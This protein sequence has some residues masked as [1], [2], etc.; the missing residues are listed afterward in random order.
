AEFIEN[1]GTVFRN[2]R[3]CFQGNVE[4]GYNFIKYSDGYRLVPKGIISDFVSVG[5]DVGRHEDFTVFSALDSS[6]YLVGFERFRKLDFQHQKDRLKAF[7]SHFPNRVVS[8][9]ARG[10]G[11]SFYEELAR[12]GIYMEGIKL[13]NPLKNELI[14][15]LILKLDEEA[16]RGPY[17]EVL[18]D[19]LEAFTYH[20]SS[21]GNP[22]YSAPSN[23]HDDCVMSLA[24]AAKNVHK[25]ATDWI[26]LK[27]RGY[28]SRRGEGNV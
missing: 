13:T 19:E 5:I 6:G 11:E 2:V 7:L 1:V 10:I 18:V 4:E 9:D 27:G 17:I 12:E 16:V 24:F 15:N 21:M 14:H 25:V 23:M 22:I 28:L 3:K 8:F 26:S 20:M